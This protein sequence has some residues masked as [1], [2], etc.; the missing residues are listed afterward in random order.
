MLFDHFSLS[1]STTSGGGN[2]PRGRLASDRALD[3]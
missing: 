2:A 1:A 3:R